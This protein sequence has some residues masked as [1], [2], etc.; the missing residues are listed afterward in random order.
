[1]SE[2]TTRSSRLRHGRR[3][4]EDDA[5]PIGPRLETRDDAL[6]PEA[7]DEALGEGEV[8]AA[9]EGPMASDG[10]VDAA[11]G[12]ADSVPPGPGTTVTR[13]NHDNFIQTIRLVDDGGVIHTL[14]SRASA[15]FTFTTPGLGR[16]E[17][18]LHPR[19]GGPAT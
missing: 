8:R 14:R 1:M 2:A 18:S 12:V 5:A 17:C 16:H 11:S 10:G 3:G 7:F 15:S 9:N 13:T 6:A 4:R 19:S